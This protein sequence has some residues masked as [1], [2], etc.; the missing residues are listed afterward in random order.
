MH[1]CIKVSLEND[2]FKEKLTEFYKENKKLKEQ[3]QRL[4]KE[5]ERQSK[6]LLKV[7]T[8][9]QACQTQ[10]ETKI[11]PN[12]KST[13]QTQLQ[14]YLMLNSS[15]MCSVCAPGGKT[16]PAKTTQTETHRSNA[17]TNT[18]DANSFNNQNKVIDS[19]C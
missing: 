2:Y 10:S 6:Q 5:N 13:G 3:V 16:P 8:H 18:F 15:N 4:V 19:F 17:A 11:N 7:G 1:N 14:K 12:V 9:E